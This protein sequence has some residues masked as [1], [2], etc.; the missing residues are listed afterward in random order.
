MSIPLYPLYSLRINKRWTLHVFCNQK[1]EV[2]IGVSWASGVFDLS[3]LKVQGKIEMI[4]HKA[5]EEINKILR[6]ALK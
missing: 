5:L 4:P 1:G 3:T 2:E 6:E